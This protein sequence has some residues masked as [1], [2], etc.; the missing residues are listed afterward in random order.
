MTSSPASNAVPPA[1]S[2]A[3]LNREQGA[4]ARQGVEAA[5]IPPGAAKRV[6]A[7]AAEA[8][9]SR[10]TPLRAASAGNLQRQRGN[11]IRPQVTWLEGKP[12]RNGRIADAATSTRVRRELCHSRGDL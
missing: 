4:L 5:A 2:L 9:S 1:V 6:A 7:V 10:I 3:A 11:G 8:Q 12:G